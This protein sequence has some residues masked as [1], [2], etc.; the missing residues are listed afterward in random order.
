[1]IRTEQFAALVASL[2]TTKGASKLHLARLGE[3]DSFEQTLIGLVLGHWMLRIV[4][5]AVLLS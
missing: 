5:T 2:V 4:R 3:S 1:M